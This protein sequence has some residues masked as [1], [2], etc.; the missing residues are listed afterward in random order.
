MG[1]KAAKVGFSV[2]KVDFVLHEV[3]VLSV[4]S[5]LVFWHK[6]EYINNYVIINRQS[7]GWAF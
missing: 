5:V 2:L 7:K 1:H 3:G 6:R 4:L